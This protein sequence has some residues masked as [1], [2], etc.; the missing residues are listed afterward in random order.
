MKDVT[1]LLKIKQ[2]FDIIAIL[3]FVNIL[4]M[5]WLMKVTVYGYKLHLEFAL[6]FK[7]SIIY[8]MVV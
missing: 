7:S 3:K 2:K 1:L 4:E 8:N 6:V 5:L